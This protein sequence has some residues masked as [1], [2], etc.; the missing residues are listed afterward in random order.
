MAGENGGAPTRQRE[1]FVRIVRLVA[2]FGRRPPSRPFAREA[3]AF[4][5]LRFAPTSAATPAV[6]HPLHE[7]PRKPGF[8]RNAKRDFLILEFPTTTATRLHD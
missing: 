8:F 6:K 3:R 4:A 1:A 2:F 5:S 7:I